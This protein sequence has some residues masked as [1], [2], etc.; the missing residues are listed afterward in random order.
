MPA[1][2]KPSVWEQLRAEFPREQIGLLPKPTK[3]ENPK[4]NCNVCGKYHGLPAIH[5]DYVGH[6]ATTQRLL[7]ADP[8]YT[9]ELLKD[10]TGQ[11]ILVY[12][13]KALESDHSVGV[14]GRLT[15]N[16]VTREEFGNGKNLKDAVSDA[17]KR[18]AMRFGVALDLWAKEDLQGGPA[19]QAKPEP[20]FP[21]PAPRKP[22]EPDAET[23]QLR[24]ELIDLAPDKDKAATRKWI[25][26]NAAQKDAAGHK[27]SLRNAI[28]AVKAKAA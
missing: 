9:F 24:Q 3:K 11:P 21:V 14:Y 26:D 17:L 19:E 4:G 22:A 8:T 6:A 12:E 16:G 20:K 27:Q 25:T 1:S 15:V 18:C 10:A 23:K 2:A 28:A 5:L 7:E 13:A